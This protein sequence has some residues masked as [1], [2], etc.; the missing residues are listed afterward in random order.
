M[1]TGDAAMLLPNLRPLYNQFHR[2]RAAAALSPLSSAKLENRI[3]KKLNDWVAVGFRILEL[4]GVWA[5]RRKNALAAAQMS[6]AQREKA[7][8]SRNST[9]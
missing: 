2:E 9:Q 3:E 5:V 6:E 4:H 8:D 1:T 7:G